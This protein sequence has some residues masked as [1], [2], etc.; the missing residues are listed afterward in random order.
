MIFSD[1][2]VFRWNTCARGNQYNTLVRPHL[3]YAIQAWSPSL[4]ADADCLEWIQWLA[5]LVKGFR[6]LSYEERLRRLSVHSL[7]RRRLNGDLTAAYNVFSGGLNLDPVLVTSS[8]TAS[9]VTS[10]NRQLDSAWEKLFAEF[11]CFSVLVSPQTPNY[12]IP[13]Y[14]IPFYANSKHYPL[15]FIIVLT[16]KL[17]CTI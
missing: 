8:V 7:H 14:I 4:V 17:F 2:A 9:S 6:R 1:K 5:K 13:F 16:F 12:A 11:P 15:S 3:E 10:F